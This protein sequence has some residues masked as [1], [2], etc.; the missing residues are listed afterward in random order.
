MD[1]CFDNV[2]QYS[3]ENHNHSVADSRPRPRKRPPEQ[4]LE[5]ERHRYEHDSEP[6]DPHRYDDPSAAHQQQQQQYHHRESLMSNIEDPAAANMFEDKKK[7]WLPYIPEE[8]DPETL[9][10]LETEHITDWNWSFLEWYSESTHKEEEDAHVA[11]L[12]NFVDE[13]WDK[14]GRTSLMLQTQNYYNKKIRSKYQELR[15]KPWPMTQIY[16]YFTVI[17]PTYKIML[18]TQLRSLWYCAIVI[19]N[20]ELHEVEKKSRDLRINKEAL[21]KYFGVLRRID[22]CMNQLDSTRSRKIR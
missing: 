5:R 8:F 19:S 1:L 16:R 20:H 21:N 22:F 13:N 9:N 17:A 11:G 2:E 12:M 15:D 7:E 4:D 3:N 18:E 14:V 6:E 10:A